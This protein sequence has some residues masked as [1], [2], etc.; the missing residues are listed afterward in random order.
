M[1]NR[2]FSFVVQNN[3]NETIEQKNFYLE[4]VKSLTK[5][6]ELQITNEAIFQVFD[7]TGDGNCGFRYSY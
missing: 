5:V 6:P 3:P 1:I 7:V 2:T 4:V